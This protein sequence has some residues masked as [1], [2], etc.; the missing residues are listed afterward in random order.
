MNTYHIRFQSINKGVLIAIYLLLKNIIKKTEE[1][2]LDS[3]PLLQLKQEKVTA[4]GSWYTCITTNLCLCL[5][6]GRVA[7]APLWLLVYNSDIIFIH[8]FN[9][10]F[11]KIILGKIHKNIKCDYLM[12]KTS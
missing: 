2:F 4:S 3:V 8:L 6:K 1:W 5:L 10:Y 11:R 12:T 7:H 9:F